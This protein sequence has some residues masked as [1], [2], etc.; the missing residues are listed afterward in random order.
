MS[1]AMLDDAPR[2]TDTPDRETRD[3]ITLYL[4]G[5]SFLRLHA[6]LYLGVHQTGSRS[7]PESKM[8]V[9]PAEITKYEQ[10]TAI[11]HINAKH[12]QNLDHQKFSFL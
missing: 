7:F 3:K 6:T 9:V 11:I 10:T 4:T 2:Q 5:K 12:T 1:N 8:K